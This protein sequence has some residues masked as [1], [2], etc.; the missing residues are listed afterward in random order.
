M[1]TLSGRVWSAGVS[2]LFSIEENPVVLQLVLC[3]YA[4]PLFSVLKVS[5]STSLEKEG[6]V[7]YSQSPVIMEILRV[8]RGTTTCTSPLCVTPIV[9]SHFRL[10]KQYN[11]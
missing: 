7:K 8:Y 6:G 3:Y 11:F 1:A 4:L 10:C 2:R 9:S 5:A